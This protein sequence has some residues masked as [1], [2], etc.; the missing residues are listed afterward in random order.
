[1]TRRFGL[2]VLIAW[3]VLAATILARYADVAVPA[4]YLVRPLVVAA[5]LS[6]VIGAGALMTR[7]WAVPVAAGVAFL[8]AF[9]N[10]VILVAVVAIL[11]V[12]ELF[13]RRGRI[14]GNVDR[15]VLAVVGIFLA[16]GIVRSLLLFEPPAMDGYQSVIGGPR[17]VVILLDGYPRIDTLARLGF[18][19]EPF[20]NELESRGFDHLPSAR[21][22]HTRTQK[23]LLALLTNQPVSDDEVKVEASRD[24]RGEMIVPPG[25][26]EVD[27]PMGFVTMG[28]G[29]H[30]E[31]IG[32]T[33]FEEQLI[34]K[35]V[36]GVLAADWAW[37]ALLAG[38]R[39]NVAFE[40]NE[41]TTI[42]ANRV[43]VHLMVPHPPFLP[44]QNGT[45][46]IPRSCWPTCGL[47]A[48]TSQEM[49]ISHAEWAAGMTTQVEWVNRQLLPA[50]D[51]VLAQH[52]DAVIVLFSD[53]GGREDWG[54]E[55]ELHR[56][57]LAAR[58]PDHPGLYAD[59]PVAEEIIRV[60]LATYRSN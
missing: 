21:S 48:H 51:R 46:A 15:P 60:L 26:V 36:V 39:S 1:M 43:F 53:H 24:I 30:V 17:M 6:V 33:D 16:I 4:G 7:S 23:T 18:D 49:E 19:N 45:L 57:F 40:L 32:P 8:V 28:P 3:M 54:D 42:D 50:I 38:L 31:T 22:E 52:S 41:A 10:L 47:G 14:Q 11:I 12:L 9:F 5:G 29:P 44:E 13:R 25:F 34:G 20:V 2:A 59:N 37:A 27:P 56:S 35:S 55:A 58:T